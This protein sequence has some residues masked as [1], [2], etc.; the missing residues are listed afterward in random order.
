MKK[1]NVIFDVVYMESFEVEANNKKEAQQKALLVFQKTSS[2]C[3]GSPVVYDIEL[4]PP[5]AQ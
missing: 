4:L 3:D 2:H 1:F 5:S